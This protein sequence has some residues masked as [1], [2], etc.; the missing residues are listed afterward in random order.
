MSSSLCVRG[1]FSLV[2]LP[3]CGLGSHSAKVPGPA[4]TDAPE[5]VEGIT[6]SLDGAPL[7]I[8]HAIAYSEYGTKVRAV[9]ADYPL[10]CG[11]AD[12]IVRHDKGHN[13]VLDFVHRIQADGSYPP[14]LTGFGL[15]PQSVVFEEPDT[16]DWTLDDQSGALVGS[17]RLDAVLPASDV[18]GK[19]ERTLTLAGP[20]RVRH[21]GTVGASDHPARPQE[22]LALIVSGKSFPVQSAILRPSDRREGHWVLQLGSN[23]ASCDSTWPDGPVNV[24]ATFTETGAVTLA[25]LSGEAL[26]PQLNFNVDAA[27]AT[28]HVK[29]STNLPQTG[30]VELQVDGSMDGLGHRLG[31]S[32]TVSAV[33][34]PPR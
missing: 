12:G 22:G 32:G 16:L 9:F 20:V 14:V 25:H 26:H 1:L 19:P 5:T 18:Y 13:V 28:M 4:P 7:S 27:A 3:A 11:E 15:F 6:A 17:I 31:L 24:R 33:L 2:V 23:P 29:P 30:E 8:T 10:G 21:C 34:C